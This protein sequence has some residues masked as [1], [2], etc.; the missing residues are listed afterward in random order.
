MTEK[1]M[2]VTID[3]GLTTVEALSQVVEPYDTDNSVQEY[4]QSLNGAV[5]VHA[6]GSIETTQAMQV[7]SSDFH[8]AFKGEI[9]STIRDG[10]THRVLNDLHDVDLERAVCDVKGQT[11]SLKT[12]LDMGYLS[13]DA[14]GKLFEGQ[15]LQ[16]D[17]EEAKAKTEAKQKAA[18]APQTL[19]TGKAAGYAGLMNETTG[20][21]FESLLVSTISQ[22]VKGEQS[23]DNFQSIKDMAAASGQQPLEVAKQMNGVIGNLENNAKNL[24]DRNYGQGVGDK[25]FDWVLDNCGSSVVSSIYHQLYLGRVDAIKQIVSRYQSKKKF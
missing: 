23:I 18:K 22:I 17:A 5:T 14:N 9:M 13:R 24:I 25:A 19:L 16:R 1:E 4:L 8:S 3:G 20:G 7:N 10:L 11:M 21:R 2:K 6:D 12:A 15:G